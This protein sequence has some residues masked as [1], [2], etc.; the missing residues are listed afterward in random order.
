M[1]E[2]GSYE[3]VDIAAGRHVE[4]GKINLSFCFSV[5]FASGENRQMFCS[6]ILHLSFRISSSVFHL[7]CIR[8]NIRV[9]K[10]IFR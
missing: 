4:L 8:Y 9:A 6:L 3:D 2:N 1:C 10:M 7:F 5:P